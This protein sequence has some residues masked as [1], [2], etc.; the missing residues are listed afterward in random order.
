MANGIGTGDPRGFN[1]GRSSNFREGSRVRQTPEEGRKTYRPKRCEN[2]NKDEDNSPKNLNDKKIRLFDWL[3]LMTRQSVWDHN[4]S[5]TSLFKFLRF[6]FFFRD[7]AHSYMISNIPI[8]GEQ[9]IVVT[10][11]W[12]LWAELPTVTWLVVMWHFQ[13]LVLPLLGGRHRSE[14]NPLFCTCG[15]VLFCKCLAAA[16]Q[17]YLFVGTAFVTV[18]WFGTFNMFYNYV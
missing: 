2:N 16:I 3:I 8:V 13:R 7:F 14:R 18:L 4:M 15:Q 5:R 10:H 1:K 6:F 12:D 11:L 9:N 17:L